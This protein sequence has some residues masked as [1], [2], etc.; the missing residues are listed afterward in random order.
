MAVVD[1][2][3]FVRKAVE[4][5]LDNSP[6]VE[7]VGVAATGEELLA[8]LDEWRP[9]VITLDLSM[10]GMGGLRTLDRV[11]EVRPLPVIVLSTHAQAGAP[12]TIEALHRGA[13]DF[14]DKG[15]YSLVD[16][17]ALGDLLM[18]KILEVAATAKVGPPPPEPRPAPPPQPPLP[19]PSRVAYDAVLIGAST[20]GPIAV[21]RILADLGPTLPVPVLVVQHMPRG[22]TRAFA[23]RLNSHLPLA[24]REATDGERLEAS[25]VYIGPAGRHL[26]IARDPREGLVARLAAEPAKVAHRPSVDVLFDSALEVLGARALALLLTGMGADGAAAMLRLEKAGGY[27]LAQDRQSSAVFGMPR[28]AIERGAVREVL[29]LEALGARVVELLRSS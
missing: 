14:I 24:V 9:D 20:G 11:M 6:E 10:P 7:V 23:D 16:F 5:I 21:Q 1:D 19:G 3:S 25:T 17:Q 27:T 8:Q 29:A 4:R 12:A 28:S 2:S 22:F 13:V 18:G 15:R 26:T